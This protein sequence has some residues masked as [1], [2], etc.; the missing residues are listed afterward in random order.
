MS[1]MENL[2]D[3]SGKVIFEATMP[4]RSTNVT[5][6]DARGLFC[7]SFILPSSLPLSCANR[8]GTAPIDTTVIKSH[9]EKSVVI[10]G[11]SFFFTKECRIFP[12]EKLVQPDG[13]KAKQSPQKAF[14]E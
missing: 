11:A 5:V 7:S 13:R 8:M 4:Y 12:A 2:P 1:S 6:A 9:F 14:I 10:A 3:E